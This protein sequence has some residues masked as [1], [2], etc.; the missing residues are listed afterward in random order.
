LPGSLKSEAVV[1]RRTG[2]TT[3]EDPKVQQ[4]LRRMQGVL[5]ARRYVMMD[6]DIRVEQVEKAI[7]V[8]P[9]L[10]SP[11]VSPLHNEGWVAVRAMVPS[12]DAQRI[13]D[14]LYDLGA[15]AI[16][17]TGIRWQRP[18]Y[19]L[20]RRDYEGI[21]CF[22]VVHNRDFASFRDAYA[23]CPSRDPVDRALYVDVKTYLVDDILTKVDR[24]SMA[25]SLWRWC[26][27]AKGLRPVVR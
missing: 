24:M 5:V 2:E 15:R 21:P 26:P 18:Q 11:T 25:V 17:T 22:E 6:Y 4:F 12:K 14:D 20:K 13:M 10:E 23:A 3:E 1:I 7:A 19:E 9:G 16:L 8:T 27:Y